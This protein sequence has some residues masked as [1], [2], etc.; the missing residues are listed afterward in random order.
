MAASS[1]A[2]LKGLIGFL[3]HYQILHLSNIAIAILDFSLL[4][5][6]NLSLFQLLRQQWLSFLLALKG[7]SEE[8]RLNYYS[9]SLLCTFTLRYRL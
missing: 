3:V 8:E 1:C 5:S 7:N 2:L 6:L 4:L 9:F